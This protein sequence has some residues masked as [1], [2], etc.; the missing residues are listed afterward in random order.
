MATLEWP[1]KNVPGLTQKVLIDKVTNGERPPLSK[2]SSVVS[3]II[4]QTWMNDEHARKTA[5]QLLSI[6]SGAAD[7]N[8]AS[9]AELRDWE[10]CLFQEAESKLKA[11]KAKAGQK[12][13][14]GAGGA[15]AGP[16]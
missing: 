11:A 8:P 16:S 13:Q 10:D 12:G 14:T 9:H 6:V 4:K 7:K 3:S 15:G 2:T 5:V 1:W